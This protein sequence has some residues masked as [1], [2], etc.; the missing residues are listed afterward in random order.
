VAT[1]ASRAAEELLARYREIDR[2]MGMHWDAPEVRRWQAATADAL[3]R[4]LGFHPT[5]VEFQGLRFR[6]GPVHAAAREELAGIP[7]EAHDARLRQDLAE[8]K[9]LLQRA[10]LAAGLD[11]EAPPP[12]AA[13]AGED[14]VGAAVRSQVGLS[15]EARARAAE[16][17]AQLRAALQAERPEWATV[18]PALRALLEVGLPVA[19]AALAAVAAR[20]ADLR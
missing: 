1:V 9:R 7:A 18:R 11:P 5:V 2:L 14:P 16:A 19:R 20:L 12:E 15:E 4:V 17:A 10:L 3:R 13:E 6:A 8:A